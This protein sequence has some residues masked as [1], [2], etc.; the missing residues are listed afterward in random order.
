MNIIHYVSQFYDLCYENIF[1]LQH[2]NFFDLC[3]WVLYKAELIP[4]INLSTISH[5]NELLLPVNQHNYLFYLKISLVQLSFL[6]L[7]IA[8]ILF[9]ISNELTSHI[10]PDFVIDNL[11]TQIFFPFKTIFRS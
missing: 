11:H 1:S 5:D 2:L 9:L 7:Q 3:Y 8:S 6:I 4:Y 10:L